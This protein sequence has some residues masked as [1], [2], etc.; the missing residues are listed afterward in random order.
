MWDG[1]G[2]NLGDTLIKDSP[3]LLVKDV[4]D[5]SLLSKK[6]SQLRK[7]K[8]ALVRELLPFSTL[9]PELALEWKTLEDPGFVDTLR[10]E[11][12]SIFQK[13]NLVEEAPLQHP[14]IFEG[15]QG[16]LLDR[17]FGFWPFVT[18]S[19]PPRV[20]GAGRLLNK[21]GELH[22]LGVLRVYMT[23]HGPGPFV[24]EDSELSESLPD[25]INGSDPWQGAFRCG[26][27]DVPALRYALAINGGMDSLALTNLDRLD[28]CERLRVCVAYEY[29]DGIEPI[30]EDLFETFQSG[31]RGLI[32]DIRLAGA[33]AGQAERLRLTEALFRCR[34]VYRDFVLGAGDARDPERFREFIDYLEGEAGVG[35]AVSLLSVGERAEDTIQLFN[36]GNN[37]KSKGRSYPLYRI[38]GSTWGV[39]VYI[40]LKCG[41]KPPPVKDR[42]YLFASV[43]FHNPVLQFFL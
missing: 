35:L 7:L 32:R 3:A 34:P 30:P 23:R 26:W 38:G 33:E 2:R 25:P 1:R 41:N 37:L 19:T 15:A 8:I 40:R 18:P 27:F 36:P 31:A 16:T 12:E 4:R 9:S 6:L 13:L 43:P 11:Y 17:R 22:R 10:R 39:R 14:V 24:T 28:S 21:P 42:L 20:Q 29:G 5:S